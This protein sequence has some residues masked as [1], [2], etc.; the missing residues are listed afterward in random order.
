MWVLEMLFTAEHGGARL[1][2]GFNELGGLFNP[3]GSESLCIFCFL[4]HRD[5]SII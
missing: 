4:N 5:S 3:G 2:T 1:I